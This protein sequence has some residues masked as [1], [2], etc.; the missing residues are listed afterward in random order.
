MSSETTS[1]FNK[2]TRC[3]RG[4]LLL[5]FLTVV[6]RGAGADSEVERK[7]R[8]QQQLNQ[9]ERIRSAERSRI[10]QDERAMVDLVI[11]RLN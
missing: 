10:D 1:P 4:A 3:T 11:H 5:A 8:I 7:N 6:P 2:M 9:V